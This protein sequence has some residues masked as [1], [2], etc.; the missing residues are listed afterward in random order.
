MRIK[1]TGVFA[2]ACCLTIVLAAFASAV[3]AFPAYV[4]TDRGDAPSFTL[5]QAPAVPPAAFGGGPS[6]AAP[7]S[8]GASSPGWLARA[9]IWILETQQ[10]LHRDLAKAVRQLRADPF[11]AGATLILLS[12]VYG[13][14]HAVGPGH[15]KA[16]ISSYIVA[17]RQTARRGIAISFASAIV[18]GC[19]A[20][21][22][23]LVLGVL[24]NMAGV[25]M[26]AA[27]AQME[28]ISFALVALVGAWLFFGQVR[29]VARKVDVAQWFPALRRE[30]PL[31]SLSAAAV[32]QPTVAHTHGHHHHGHHHSHKDY[33]HHHHHHHDEDCGC[34]HSHIP[35]AKELEGDLSWRRTAAIVF[36]VGIRP[37]TG[38]ILVLVFAL[39]QGLFWAGV[40][41][42]FA[43]AIGT[44]ITV[45]ALTV[46]AVTA[47]DLT[48]R[49]AA[50]G[51]GVWAEIFYDALA[52][53]GTFLILAIGL[54]LFFGSL[55]PARPF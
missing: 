4:A 6:A 22:L 27:V 8:G 11:Y 19:S 7:A 31:V 35:S 10:Q 44:A 48:A 20:V 3:H 17:N 45:A 40:I 16:I 15:G 23:V 36:A 12:F 32:A 14:L 42:T 52:L 18:Q 54:V 26:Q 24:L 55:G 25:R 43:M 34:G 5:A 37:C 49:A 2:A 29:R 13:V 1:L 33:S 9:Q 21:A 28:T 38:A 41:A 53:S 51:H 30:K 47:R 50:S 39:T 46:A